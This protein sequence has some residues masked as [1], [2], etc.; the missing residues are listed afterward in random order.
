M[1]EH[2][3]LKDYKVVN[4]TIK[5]GSKIEIDASKAQALIKAGIV[6]TPKAA[7]KP[8]EKTE[9]KQNSK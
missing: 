2:K 4:V 9:E 1:E 7:S 8:K 5:K 3:L 6:A